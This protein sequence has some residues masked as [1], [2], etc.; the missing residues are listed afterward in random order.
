MT[1]G[2]SR[3][4]VTIAGVSSTDL[5]QELGLRDYL[6]VLRRR[7]TAVILCALTVVGVALASS[8]LQTPV[9][10]GKAEL[11]L[12]AR[13]TESLFDPN[14]GQATDRA[15]AVQ[16][17]IRVLNSQPVR[18]E[19]RRQIGT[20][21]DIAA[22]PAGLT[23][24]IE[25]RA[26]STIPQRAA[27]IANAYAS[28]YIDF[29]RTQ[30]VDDVL[31]A[32]QQI[33]AKIDDLQKQIDALDTEVANAPAPAQAGVRQST[34]SQRDTLLTQQGLFKQKLDELQVDAALKSGGAQLVTR[35]TVPTSP[36]EP[37]PVR[38]GLLA[39]GVGLLLGVGLAFLLDHLDDSVKTKDD[40][41][42]VAPNVPVIGL[43]PAVLGWKVTDEPQVVSIDDPKSAA[44]EAYRTLR[45][46]IQFLALEEPIRTLHVT[47][48]NAQEGKT[49]TL[50]NLGVALARAGQRV[51]VVCADLRRPRLHEFFGL[52][53][54]VGFT[55]VLLGKVPLTAALQPVAAQP[56]LSI[57]ASGPLPPN[58][59]ELLSSKRTVDVLTSLRGHCDIVLVDSPPVLPVT[60]ALVI[61]GR[62]DATILV[63]V[64]GATSRKDT[65]RA[66]ELLEQVDAPLVGT[67][68]NGV[69]TEGA[70][71][72]DYGYY[73]YEESTRPPSDGNGAKTDWEPAPQGD[74][75]GRESA[76]KQ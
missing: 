35:A 63:C 71:G 34:G 1:A 73:R 49:T 68:L 41:D 52:E 29:R 8:L 13:S 11:L 3:R 59:S 48:P 45:T 27:D 10:E 44:S 18:D 42:R 23:D 53:N 4:E 70:Y 61:S 31:G 28:A 36:V 17:E 58:P 57:L 39:M 33:R 67:V 26:R 62:V 5:P 22:S 51:V 66:V 40:L 7:K 37:Q 21:P 50:C 43:I 47:S 30:A 65:S 54:A 16:T 72:Y 6:R 15:R 25:V 24:V 60:D 46:S 69:T 12:Q 56:R 74:R 2:R 20:A 75:T 64:S 76:T 19:V 38:S 55:S 32:A 14:T 9:Y